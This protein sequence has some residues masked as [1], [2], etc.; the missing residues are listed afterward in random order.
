MANKTTDF[1]YAKRG[2]LVRLAYLIIAVTYACVIGFGRLFRGRVVVLCYHAVTET[3]LLEFKKQMQIVSNRAIKLTQIYEIENNN[4]KVCVTFDDAFECLIET[5]I[6]VTQNLDIPIAIFAVTKNMGDFPRWEMDIDR[7]DRKY[8]IMTWQQLIDIEKEDHCLIGSHTVS[9]QPLARL[10]EDLLRSE[11]IESK[12]ELEKLLTHEITSLALPHGSYNKDVIR[13]A[14]DAGY[15]H[16]LTLDEITKPYRWPSNTIGRFVVS[17]D[18]WLIEFYLTAIGAY[19][20]LYPWRRSLRFI[21]SII[22]Q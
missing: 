17:P 8:R 11:L 22:R 14:T 12:G 19:A 2:F 13:V 6:P 20:W 3:Q 4:D 5:A 7:P 1:S 10:P 16:I 18:M 9:H 15:Q 21:R